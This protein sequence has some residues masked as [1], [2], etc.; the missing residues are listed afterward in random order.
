VSNKLIL[1]AMLI[2]PWLTLF[3]MKKESIKRYAPVIIFTALM[4]SVTQ[5]MAYSLNWW[6]P[7][8]QIVPW[9]NINNISYSFGSFLV[10]TYWIFYFTNRKFWLY[11]LVN[12]VL[13]GLWAFP[14]I[15]YL[16]IRHIFQRGTFSG[17]SAWVL[18]VSQAVLLYLFQLWHEKTFA[19]KD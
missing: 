10:L 13:D 7:S 14:V 18:G 17:W 4:V 12:I 2:V 6:R 5:E 15:H 8:D 1:W 16:A 3:F 9:G 11:L 19:L